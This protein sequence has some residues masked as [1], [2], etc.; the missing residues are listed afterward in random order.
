MNKKTIKDIA[1]AGKRVVMRVDFNVPVKNGKVGDDTRITAAVPS[2]KY[3]LEQGASLVLLSHLGRPDGQVALEFSLKPCADRLA[4]LLGKEVKF[5]SD[6]VGDAVVAQANALK[7]GEV[8]VCEN[9]RFHKEEDMKTKTDED[10]QKMR[11]F[12]KELAKL[13]NVYVN[14]AFGT[15]HRAHAS[16]AVI[17]E[18]LDRSNCV[19]GFLMDK[20][21]QYLGKAVAHPERPFV[22][23]IG[24]A[25]VSGKLEVLS[26]L[27]EKVDTILIG[28][29][30][31]YTFL[32]ALGHKIGGSLCEDDLLETA[33]ATLKKAEEKKVKFL[34]PVDNK[35]ADKFDN[36]A[37][38]K[39]VGNDIEDGWMALDIGPKT[40][41]LYSKEI[42]SAKTVVW[43]GPMGCFEMPNFASGTM[44]V[45]KAVADSKSVS[46]IGGGDSVSAVNQSGLADKMSHISTGGGASLE[47][48][49]GKTLPGVAVL[50]DA[51]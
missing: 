29:G 23:I 49:E 11:G 40:I 41:E 38:T 46:I 51:E 36:A 28:G 45:C 35:I 15:A 25:K 39:I 33:K 8:M 19:A 3:I 24:G 1:L 47:F 48:L 37:N 4:E 10:K 12:A 34:L 26:S 43:N 44:S 2:I 27:M 6:C 32:K 42:A 18:F 22:A 13:G 14:D 9:T 50:A 30:M 21:L 20:E 31:A 7:P 16:T 5:A 17:T